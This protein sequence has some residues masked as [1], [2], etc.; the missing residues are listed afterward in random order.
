MRRL[1]SGIPFLG[2][3]VATYFDRFKS[4]ASYIIII[5]SSSHTQGLKHNNPH[6]NSIV[7][8]IW[9]IQTSINLL[10]WFPR[11][12]HMMVVAGDYTIRTFEG[13]EQYSKPRLLL[14]HPLYNKN[15]NNADI[16]LIKVFR[17]K[18]SFTLLF[19]NVMFVYVMGGPS[20]TFIYLLYV[21]IFQII[22]LMKSN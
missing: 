1:I 18:P 19:Y 6:N 20:V 9:S 14:T 10:P 22:E 4:K 15:T 12:E 11:A 3:F 2:Y 17:T 21:Q 5:L 16:M 7:V 13:T 8:C